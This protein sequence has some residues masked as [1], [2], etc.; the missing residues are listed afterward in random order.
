MIGDFAELLQRRARLLVAFFDWLQNRSKRREPIVRFGFS[1]EP[2][3]DLI[4]E[5]EVVF[6]I[7]CRSRCDLSYLNTN[8]VIS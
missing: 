6:G 8:E 4:G 5:L 3:H 1:C 2:M 7:V